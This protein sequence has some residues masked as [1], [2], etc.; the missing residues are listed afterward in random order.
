[1]YLGL[2][3]SIQ[4]GV[5]YTASFIVVEGIAAPLTAWGTYDLANPL[6]WNTPGFALLAS[7][8]LSSTI[9]AIALRMQVL[10]SSTLRTSM[11]CALL[12][13]LTTWVGEGIG[14]ALKLWSYRP[15]HASMVGV[16]LWIPLSYGAAF[17]AC[18]LL[19]SRI[20]GG[21]VQ[22]V[23]VGVAWVVFQRLFS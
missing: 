17:A 12:A 15:G 5:V 23:L 7:L 19:S 9:A 4:F 6:L 22:A 14:A 1:M 20:V 16:P 10:G 11:A 3:R 18:P 2:R 21:A 13:L 8:L